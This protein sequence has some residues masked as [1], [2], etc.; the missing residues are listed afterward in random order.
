MAF[1]FKLPEI[2]EGVTEGEVVKWLVDEGDLVKEDQPIV[3]VMTDKA[4]VEISSPKGGTIQKR[5]VQEGQLIQVG[6]VLVL[7]DEGGNGRGAASERVTSPS[8]LAAPPAP[9]K[10]SSRA[11][12]GVLASPTT[13]K[14]A[15]EMNI[16]LSTVRGSG[17][18]GR[19]LEKDL[20]KP[21]TAE[22]QTQTAATPTGM[23]E[24]IPLRGIRKKIAE[25]M[26]RSKYTA[27]H[28]T[29]VDEVDMTDLVRFREET[30]KRFAAEGIKLTYLP[31]VVK[32]L[33]Q[34]LKEFPSLNG[35][36]DDAK[37]EIIIKHYYNIGI[38]TQ[39]DN[40]L[41]VP[42]LKN[43]DRKEIKGLA[44]EIQTL[45]DRAR[46]G[47]L[48]M[49]DLQGGTFTI[50]STGSLAGILAT[51]IINH[52]ELGILG[53]HRIREMPVV[54]SGQIVIRHMGYLSLSLDHRII[55][56]AVGA[57]FLKSLIRR[58]ENPLLLSIDD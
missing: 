58:L 32:A 21:F 43:A 25:H 8:V 47:K 31:F 53:V 14:R 28:F 27:P 41:I 54:R 40:G 10:E 46:H 50:T 34:S 24:R 26:V 44:R 6:K 4:T 1:E 16:D 15:R 7:I 13:R 30:K 52:P 55:D 56:G 12:A 39:T 18:L 36:M 38:A 5:F 48:S 19:V 22:A 37:Q 17:P 2:G 51:P 3:E 11:Q 29:Q 35:S 42:V 20:I 33:C 45:A 9:Q 49:D 23:E 57:A